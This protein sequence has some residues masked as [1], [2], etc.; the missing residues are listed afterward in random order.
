MVWSS[1]DRDHLSALDSNL[2]GGCCLTIIDTKGYNSIKHG[3][4]IRSGGHTLIA[5]PEAVPGVPPAREEMKTIGHSETGSSHWWLRQIGSEK[6]HFQCV[7][8]SLNW[9][10]TNLASAMCLISTSIQN[11]IAF[12]RCY[13]GAAPATQRFSWPNDAFFE[14][15]WKRH[16]GVT[17]SWFS[18]PV[19]ADMMVAWSPADI[20]NMYAANKTLLAC[21]TGR[22]WPASKL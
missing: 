14:E 7:Q 10:V 1:I 9:D 16:S 17:S 4:R 15:P 20:L 6:E 12:V 3:L 21:R 11:L 19:T 18:V 2:T 8:R 22:R 5:A 13:N